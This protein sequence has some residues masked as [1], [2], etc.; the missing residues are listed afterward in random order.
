M[1][2]DACKDIHEAQKKGKTNNKCTC[3]CHISYS[4]NTAG[5]CTCNQT[6]TISGFCPV[7]GSTLFFNTTGVCPTGDITFP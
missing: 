7:H 2:C 5:I 3:D 4:T 1:A 6:N